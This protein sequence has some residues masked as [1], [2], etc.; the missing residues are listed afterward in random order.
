M[1]SIIL[2]ILLL[3]ISAYLIAFSSGSNSLLILLVLLGIAIL[4]ALFAT[5]WFSGNFKEKLLKSLRIVFPVTFVVFLLGYFFDTLR[6][7]L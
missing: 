1:K 5:I 4:G 6:V 2:T 3:G 7:M